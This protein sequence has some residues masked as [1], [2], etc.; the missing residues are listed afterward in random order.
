MVATSVAS[1]TV[2]EDEV[3]EVGG[4][5]RP[6][7]LDRNGNRTS[8]SIGDV[9]YDARNFGECRPRFVNL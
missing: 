9:V 3:V 4:A 1:R 2:H 8:A 7:P 5:C 6:D